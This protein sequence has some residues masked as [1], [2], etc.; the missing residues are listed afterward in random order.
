VGVGDDQLHA[1]KPTGHQ[2]AQE[3]RPPSPVLA[4]QHVDPEDLAVTFCAHTRRDDRGHIHDAAGLPAA[5]GER[6]Y[7]HIHIGSAIQRPGPKGGHLGVQAL[8]ELGDLGLAQAL[9]PKG[10]DQALHASGGHPTHVA[11]GHHRHQGT[12]GAPAGLQQPV[13]E[14]AALPELGDRQLDRADPGVQPPLAV[15][16]APVDPVRCTLA[17]RSAAG[18]VGLSTHERLDERRHQLP[19]QIR[20]GLLQVLA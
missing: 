20:V 11:L 8:G 13:R 7:P 12:L 5:L 18:R 10:L 17:K 9:D 19:Q 6:V 14:V 15:A 16:V 4:G 2:I 3:R 1:G